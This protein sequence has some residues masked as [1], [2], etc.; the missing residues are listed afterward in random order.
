MRE[1]RGHVSRDTPPGHL[2]ADKRPENQREISQFM[3]AYN[4]VSDHKNEERGNAR[5][6]AS[7]ASC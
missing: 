3:V 4:L 2:S 1:Q 6:H 7:I 5:N